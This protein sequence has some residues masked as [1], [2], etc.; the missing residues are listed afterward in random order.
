MEAPSFASTWE[1]VKG[2]LARGEIQLV[3][4][5]DGEVIGWCDILRRQFEG[6]RHCGTLGIGVLPEHRGRGVGKRL[7]TEALRQAAS[8]GIER[9]EL[10]VYASNVRARALYE[11]LG[12]ITEGRK[13]RARKLDGVYDDVIVMS[14]FLT[15]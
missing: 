11:K 3:A 1:F 14:R 12:F 4:I 10:E 2:N 8:K 9:V 6:Y 7:I 13:R 5:E 15:T